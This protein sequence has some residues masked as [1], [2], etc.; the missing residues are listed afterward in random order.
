MNTN[1]IGIVLSF[2]FIFI[3][4]AL[5]TVSQKKANLSEEFSRK[6]IH[7]A[8]GNWILI[9]VYFFDSILICWLFIQFLKNQSRNCS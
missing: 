5:V 3:V 7:I 8:V 2:S 1:I 4:L 9:A 6:A